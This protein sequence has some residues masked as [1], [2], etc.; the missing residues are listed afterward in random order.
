MEQ[1]NLKLL[2]ENELYPMVLA[3]SNDELAKINYDTVRKSINKFIGR[4]NKRLTIE[5]IDFL[6]EYIWTVIN[7]KRN[8]NNDKN[9]DEK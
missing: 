8:V 3:N 6:T 7:K 1:F 5:N 2:I 9:L 4:Y